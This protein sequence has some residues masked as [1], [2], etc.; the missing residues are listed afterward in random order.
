ME[1]NE[2]LT[3][4]EVE[5]KIKELLKNELE[6]SFRLGKYLSLI[7]SNRLYR[8]DYSTFDDYVSDR[9]DMKARTAY[10]Y[11]SVYD[12]FGGRP[13]FADYTFS[14]LVEMAA[15]SDEQIASA[16]ITP[17]MSVRE[18]RKR[19]KPVAEEPVKLGKED[20]LETL[21]TLLLERCREAVLTLDSS[22]MK[23]DPDGSKSAL[24]DRLASVIRSTVEE[25]KN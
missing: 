21:R 25:V 5:S 1:N 8:T 6:N 3:L 7:C 24:F 18:I 15:F 13:E 14:R 4:S 20:K 12:R 19:L 22:V 17:D 9:L 11:I 2:L 16:G 10:K 23:T